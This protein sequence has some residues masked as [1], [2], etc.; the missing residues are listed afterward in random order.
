MKTASIISV[1]LGGLLLSSLLAAPATLKVASYNVRTN[2]SRDL[3]DNGWNKRAARCVELLKAE[4]FDIFGTQEAQQCHIKTIT[5]IGYKV[6]GRPRDN[7]KNSEYSTIF[8]DPEVLELQKTET[9]WLSETPNVPGSRSWRSAC[10][11][12]CTVGF[13]THKA[14]GK[15]FVFVNTHLDHKS[16]LARENGVKLIIDYLKKLAPDCPCILTGDFNARPDNKI[17]KTVTDFM[18]DARNVAEKVLPGPR[19]TFHGYQADPAK[20]KM[21][22]PIDYIFVNKNAVKVKSFKAVDDF[23]NGFASSDHFPVVAEVTL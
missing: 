12:I 23:K 10:T 18:A 14:S 21:T 1:L 9:F 2:T 3:P 19:Q 13:F 11:R 5:S 16:Q 17:Y 22:V 20:R 4:K 6:I 8:Y 15:K 7:T